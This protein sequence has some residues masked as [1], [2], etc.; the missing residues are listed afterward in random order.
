MKS[1]KRIFSI[2]FIITTF[3]GAGFLFSACEAEPTSEQVLAESLKLDNSSVNND[4]PPNDFPAENNTTKEIEKIYITRLV[5]DSEIILLNNGIGVEFVVDFEPN[6]TTENIYIEIEDE[7]IINFADNISEDDKVALVDFT[8][9][10]NKLYPLKAGETRI[11]IFANSSESEQIQFFCSVIVEEIEELEIQ[12]FDSENNLVNKFKSGKKANGDYEI[13][14]AIVSSLSNLEEN[15][16]EILKSEGIEVLET[17]KEFYNSENF[18]YFTFDFYILGEG[19]DFINI[20]IDLNYDNSAEKIFSNETVIDSEN[21]IQSFSA[22]LSQEE[23]RCLQD[24]EENYLLYFINDEDKNNLANGEGFYNYYILDILNFSLQE[25]VENFQIEIQNEDVIQQIFA[26][27]GIKI[28]AQNIGESKI[29]ISAMDGS[30]QIF[31]LNVKVLDCAPETLELNGVN[32]LS[33][34]FIEELGF[35]DIEIY[36]SNN[37]GLKSSFELDILI[38]GSYSEFAY[39]NC[40]DEN[41]VISAYKTAD[42]GNFEINYKFESNFE[43]KYSVNLVINGETVYTFEIFVKLC[44]YYFVLTIVDVNN[45][46]VN[47]NFS[48]NQILINEFNGFENIVFNCRL[49]LNGDRCA[50][51]L[52]LE[53]EDPD[54]CISTF[55]Q[56]TLEQ[57]FLRVGSV[58]T[59]KINITDSTTGASI[60]LDV[61]IS[62]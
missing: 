59:L 44:D 54:N 29:I 33:E 48:E 28:I 22:S 31:E 11:K 36:S 16:L 13:Y 57:I 10:G 26:E 58:G 46:N 61:I 17:S 39:L 19:R 42:D 14:T 20:S 32:L 40:S 5:A 8:T 15:N 27:N 30:E 51:S 56:F 37:F 62:E 45:S 25:E 41:L 38:S 43:G 18:Y 50:Q 9:E 52:D 24:L 47:Y 4:T 6:N 7:S 60:S 21:F 35:E 3:I 1:L 55:Q 2:L 34:N 53:F 23:D 12:I 49:Y